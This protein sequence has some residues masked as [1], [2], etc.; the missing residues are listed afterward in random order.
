MTDQV[1]AVL[2]DIGKGVAKKWDMKVE[3]NERAAYQASLLCLNNLLA[4]IKT[5]AL[6]DCS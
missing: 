1:D 3:D 6:A 4:Q 5:L 2:T